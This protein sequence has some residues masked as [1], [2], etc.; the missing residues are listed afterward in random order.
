MP[1]GIVIELDSLVTHMS[2]LINANTRVSKL[3]IYVRPADWR[4]NG[5]ELSATFGVAGGECVNLKQA[6][7][8]EQ[9]ML[10]RVKAPVGAVNGSGICEFK[11]PKC[12]T[13]SPKFLT[14][15]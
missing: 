10:K 13:L 11:K 7:I 12:V 2:L 9:R 5:L 14:A 8:K 15:P 6:G 1:N 4:P 3:Y